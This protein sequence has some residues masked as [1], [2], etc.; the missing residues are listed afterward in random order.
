MISTADVLIIMFVT[1]NIRY[2][3]I[4]HGVSCR[5]LQQIEVMEVEHCGTRF[6]REAPLFLIFEDTGI[7]L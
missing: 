2:D 5:R 4:R 6:Q 3:T 7:P 1:G